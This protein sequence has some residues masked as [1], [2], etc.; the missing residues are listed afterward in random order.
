MSQAVYLWRVVSCCWKVGSSVVVV[1]EDILRVVRRSN[2]G[3]VRM[4][5]GCLEAVM[6]GMRRRGVASMLF[7]A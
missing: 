2:V 5:R 3:V 6:R 1:E 4:W 7:G